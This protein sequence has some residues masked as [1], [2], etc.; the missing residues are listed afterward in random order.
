MT[1]LAAQAEAAVVEAEVRHRFVDDLDGF[2]VV[3]SRVGDVEEREAR[4][5]HGGA[6]AG[7]ALAVHVGVLLHGVGGHGAVVARVGDT[8]YDGS[9]LARI[10]QLKESMLPS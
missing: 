8:V 2:G 3:I 6:V 1:G 4:R 5:A 10:R 7:V 9:L